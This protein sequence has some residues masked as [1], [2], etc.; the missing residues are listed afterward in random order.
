[1]NR[2]FV[3]AIVPAILLIVCAHTALAISSGAPEGASGAPREITCTSCHGGTANSGPGRLRIDFAGSSTYT[4]GQK[5]RMRVVVEDPNAKRWGFELSAR[6]ESNA[7]TR[8][9]SLESAN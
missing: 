6:L 9:G 3:P 7:D 4:P 1:M 2:N 8:A 5:V